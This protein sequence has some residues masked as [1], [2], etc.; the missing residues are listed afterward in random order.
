MRK[1]FAFCK[2]VPT[3][4]NKYFY[5]LN[6]LHSFRTTEISY[7]HENFCKD[8]K[9]TQIVFFTEENLFENH[10]DQKLNK[11]SFLIYVDSKIASK[12]LIVLKMIQ[13]R[14]F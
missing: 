9:F 5:C 8:H 3:N 2:D 12:E 14:H 13:K 1:L 11:S 4:H 7:K 10:E 6:C